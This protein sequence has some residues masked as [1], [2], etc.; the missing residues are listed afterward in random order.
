MPKILSL[1]PAAVPE[2]SSI[3]PKNKLPDHTISAAGELEF[4]VYSQFN[5][6]I[7]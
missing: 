3:A 4:L 6:S 1:M 5:A 7:E 2:C